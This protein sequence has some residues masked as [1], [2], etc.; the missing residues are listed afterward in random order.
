[1]S[2]QDP[3][4]STETE[5]K[6]EIAL[7][8][9]TL[10]EV[11]TGDLD[12]VAG[13][14]EN[15]CEKN[16]CTSIAQR[17]RFSDR[18]PRLGEGG[19]SASTSARAPLSYRLASDGGARSAVAPVALEGRTALHGS[20][21]GDSKTELQAN[22]PASSRHVLRSSHSHSTFERHRGLLRRPGGSVRVRRAG[23]DLLRRSRA[24]RRSSGR[25]SATSSADLKSAP[26]SPWPPLSLEARLGPWLEGAET[27]SAL[28]VE[29]GPIVRYVMRMAGRA[30]PIRALRRGQ[31][32]GRRDP[33]RARRPPGGSR[34]SH[35]SEPRLDLRAGRLPLSRMSSLGE[36]LRYRA[37]TSIQE[38][39]ERIRYYTVRLGEESP[40]LQVVRDSPCTPHLDVVLAATR[41]LQAPT[42]GEPLAAAVA[43][44]FQGVEGRRVAPVR[45]RPRRAPAVAVDP[46]SDCHRPR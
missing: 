17:S 40:L 8:V 4:K 18:E 1:M 45:P 12:D 2:N 46:L 37:N 29:P 39:P 20:A 11:P 44:A 34:P 22:E 43:S 33:H 36:H 32:R 28:S 38:T 15:T 5:E 27:E 25:A 35:A 41:A 19:C 23:G 7:P 42:M 9:P 16:V 10:E 26:R 6:I 31:R 21:G 13:G 24:T 14:M 30:D 3:K